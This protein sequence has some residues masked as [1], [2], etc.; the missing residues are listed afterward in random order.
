MAA[1]RTA[2]RAPLDAS[3]ARRDYWARWAFTT[4]QAREASAQDVAAADHLARRAVH[5]VRGWRLPAGK[6]LEIA[7]I[8]DDIGGPYPPPARHHF[9]DSLRGAGC[10]VILH[11]EQTAERLGRAFTPTDGGALHSTILVVALFGDIRAWKGRPGYSQSAR[12]QVGELVK[13][14]ESRA[15][16]VIIVQFSHPRLARELPENVPI[17][18]AW[19]GDAPMQRAAARMLAESR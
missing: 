4:E 7:I 10:E 14:A 6:S 9:A 13:K 11:D 18:C 15:R 2:S 5:L 1:G 8:D 12:A 16:D 19:G 3:L 17:V